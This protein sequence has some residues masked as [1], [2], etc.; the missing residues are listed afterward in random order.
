[1]RENISIT[2]KEVAVIIFL[3]MLFTICESLSI[4]LNNFFHEYIIFGY[5]FLFNV[6]VIFF[7]IGFFIIDLITELYNDKFAD[8][9]IYSKVI[10]QVVFVFF[11]LCGVKVAGIEHGQIAKTF[12]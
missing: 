11:G 6:S 9:F 12:F 3:S 7:C 8:Y 5:H 10:S 1:M 4:E 2:E